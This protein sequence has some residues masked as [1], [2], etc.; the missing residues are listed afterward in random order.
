MAQAVR[1]V[2]I[3]IRLLVGTFKVVVV[4]WGQVG[5]AT[6]VQASSALRSQIDLQL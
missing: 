5:V 3:G 1:V 6:V 2:A 4:A